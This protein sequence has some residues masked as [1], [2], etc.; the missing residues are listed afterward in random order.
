MRQ[1]DVF[2]LGKRLC[3]ADDGVDDDED[4][5]NDAQGRGLTYGPVTCNTALLHYWNGSY[6]SE[7]YFRVF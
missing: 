4:D 5:D 6:N 7:M 1:R 3:S 2:N